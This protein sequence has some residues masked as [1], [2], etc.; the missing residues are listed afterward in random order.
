MIT[1]K[2]LTGIGLAALLM[3]AMASANVLND[4]FTDGGRSNGADAEDGAWWSTGD[5]A[6]FTVAND[7]GSI[8]GNSLKATGVGST[9]SLMCFF[10]SAVTLA[11]VGDKLT[12]TADVRLSSTPVGNYRELN[13]VL[14]NS[15]GTQQAADNFSTTTRADDTYYESMVQVTQGGGVPIVNS[16]LFI[17]RA[18]MPSGSED[19]TEGPE[20]TVGGASPTRGTVNSSLLYS[21]S[22]VFSIG[23]TAER[24]ATGI[25]LQSTVN[26]NSTALVIDTTSYVSTFDMF[27][28]QDR[29]GAASTYYLDNV[30]VTVPEPSTLTLAALAAVSGAIVLRRRKA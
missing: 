15:A 27:M 19:F 1:T 10:P 24:V 30:L 29:A 11:N 25:Q 23:M 13:F 20:V 12:F 26:G 8:T 3:C 21:G 7:A 9:R 5:G 16:P 22:P 14:G 2:Q 17:Y 18:T 4:T 6:L 28:F